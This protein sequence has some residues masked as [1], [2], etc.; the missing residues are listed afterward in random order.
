MNENIA[1]N[2]TNIQVFKNGLILGNLCL[3]KMNCKIGSG[4]LNDYE[5]YFS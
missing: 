5:K 3:T 1:K 4:R 2:P